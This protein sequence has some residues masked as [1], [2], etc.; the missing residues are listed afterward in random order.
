[1]EGRDMMPLI[2][3]G[4]PHYAYVTSAYGPFVMVRDDEYWYNAYL[5]GELPRLYYL[6]DDPELKNSIADAN[7]E[8]CDRMQQRAVADAGG[9]IPELLRE[10]AGSN[11]P[12]CTPMQAT[13]DF[14][15]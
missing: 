11:I 15:M 14:I 6:P 4:A 10:L 3:G 9:R 2:K 1:M 5:W 8:V 12:G 7:P 13:L